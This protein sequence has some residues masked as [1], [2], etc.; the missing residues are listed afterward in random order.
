MPTNFGLIR[1]KQAFIWP[2]EKKLKLKK[3]KEKTKTQAQKS[4]FRVFF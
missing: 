1:L 4:S 2:F 3:L